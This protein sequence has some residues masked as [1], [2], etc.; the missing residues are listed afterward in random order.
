MCIIAEHRMAL[1]LPS[2]RGAACGRK[3]RISRQDKGC[4]RGKYCPREAE[5]VDLPRADRFGKVQ[6]VRR[7]IR[8]GKYDIDSRLAAIIDRIIEDLVD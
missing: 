1:H 2:R 4:G 7:Q 5:P 6:A 8:Q 3:D